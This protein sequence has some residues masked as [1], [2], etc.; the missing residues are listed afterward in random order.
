MQRMHLQNWRTNIF[1]KYKVKL[2]KKA[3]RDIEGIYAYTAN[4]KLAPENARG[5][6]NGIKKSIIELDTFPES[7]Q[8]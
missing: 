7:H 8:E 2:Y 6:V 4:E 5:P 1:D 3:Y